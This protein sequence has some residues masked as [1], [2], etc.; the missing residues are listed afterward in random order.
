MKQYCRTQQ[1]TYDVKFGYSSTDPQLRAWL[2]SS[3]MSMLG[4]LHC[5]CAD[6]VA[7]LKTNPLHFFLP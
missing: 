7:V 1:D 6:V 5:K 4:A 3:P 2:S